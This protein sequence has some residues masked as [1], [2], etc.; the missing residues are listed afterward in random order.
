MTEHIVRPTT[1]PAAG[2]GSGSSRGRDDVTTA[3]AIGRAIMAAR[4]S[5][6]QSELSRLTGIDQPTISKL[7][8]GAR[9]QPLTVWEMAQIERCTGR[10]PGFLLREA[11]YLPR[12]LTARQALQAEPG[13]D[14]TAR[15]VLAAGLDA[16]LALAESRDGDR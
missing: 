14:A 4:D 7:E 16:A 9:P 1:E 10:P 13:L 3:A 12:T 8:R 2:P 6:S 15:V 11:G 5:M